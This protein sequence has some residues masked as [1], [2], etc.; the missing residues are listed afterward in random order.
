MRT[1]QIPAAK[2]VLD[3][4]LYPRHHLDDVNVKAI[5]NSIDAGE[6]TPPVVAER[7]SLRVVD[8]FHRVTA[9]LRRDSEAVIDVQLVD[10]E[11]DAELFE[12]AMRRNARHGVR[13]SPYDRSRCVQIGTE[14]GLDVSQI[15][16]AL[17]VNVDVLGALK[18]R[19]TA[20]DT[21]GDPLPIKQSLRHLAGRKLSKKQEHA[22]QRASG[23]SV[24]FHAEQIVTAIQGE[25]CDWDDE[26]TIAA[27]REVHGLLSARFGAVAEVTA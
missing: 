18:A 2:L 5:A 1:K 27:L 14:L 22:N 8:G 3:Y 23:W 4:K 26:A 13:L 11:S 25:V 20:Y 7:T 17:A 15:A 16:G 9:H 19:K 24:R 10:Y 21:N 12:D 6:E